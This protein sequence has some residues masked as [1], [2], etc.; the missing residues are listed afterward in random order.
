MADI[1]VEVKE[2]NG[3]EIAQEVLSDVQQILK[4]TS[5]AIA[6]SAR[7]NLDTISAQ[8]PYKKPG[9]WGFWAMQKEH[10][11]MRDSIK[12]GSYETKGKTSAGGWWQASTLFYPIERGTTKGK[13]GWAD[14]TSDMYYSRTGKGY[15]ENANRGPSEAR[16]FLDPAVKENEDKIWTA[17][18]AI[19]RND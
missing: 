7:E 13:R 17:L 14:R 6:H 3:P 12:A 10:G 2:Y 18:D 16:P 1:K 11:Y 15:M 5:E 8:S 19:K 4:D 9:G